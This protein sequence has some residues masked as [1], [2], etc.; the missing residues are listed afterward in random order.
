MDTLP[1]IQMSSQNQFPPAPGTTGLLQL[2]F[3]GH[4]VLS[5]D[6]AQVHRKLFSFL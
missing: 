3:L 5:I 4:L 6:L 2:A 1:G